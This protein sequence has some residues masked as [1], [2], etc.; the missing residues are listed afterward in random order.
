MEDKL[1]KWVILV[2]NYD[3]T[4]PPGYFGNAV[5][6]GEVVYSLAKI[7]GHGNIIE[8]QGQMTGFDHGWR[9]KMREALGNGS[10]E[11]RETKPKEPAKYKAFKEE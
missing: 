10:R 7:D 11:K 6:P 2:E 5:D 3:S 4:K 9:L 1:K 8:Q